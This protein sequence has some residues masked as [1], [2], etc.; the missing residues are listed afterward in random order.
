MMKNATFLNN[1]FFKKIGSLNS[2]LQFYI[3]SN[4]K[5]FIILFKLYID[6]Y[7]GL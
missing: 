6:K 4:N 5:Y 7:C 1:F 3:S 2:M